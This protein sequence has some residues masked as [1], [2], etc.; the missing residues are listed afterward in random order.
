[1]STPQIIPHTVT[2]IS[3]LTRLWDRHGSQHHHLAVTM[4]PIIL[5]INP[6]RKSLLQISSYWSTCFFKGLNLTIFLTAILTCRRQSL[7]ILTFHDNS[8]GGLSFSCS[9]SSSC[10][11]T[12]AVLD[13]R[14]AAVSCDEGVSTRL[15][16]FSPLCWFAELENFCS[17]SICHQDKLGNG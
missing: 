16:I 13:V 10:V 3:S 1:M 8:A 6:P 4:L 12:V 7:L 5:W 11:L 17:L 9:F 14:I 2:V 15:F